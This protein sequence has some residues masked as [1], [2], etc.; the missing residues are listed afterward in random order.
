MYGCEGVCFKVNVPS[1]C[2]ADLYAPLG[3]DMG[4]GGFYSYW[5]DTV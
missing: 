2:L 1:V 3:V 4:G 5:Y